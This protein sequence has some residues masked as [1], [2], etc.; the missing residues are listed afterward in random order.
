MRV[1]LVADVVGGVR[2]FALELAG[3]LARCGVG[4]DLALLG[5]SDRRLAESL[6]SIAP[7]SWQARD[8]R[9]EWMPEPW[10]DVRRASNWVAELVAERRPDVLHMNTFTPVDD[11]GIPVLLTVH[12]C[13]LTW[14]HSVHGRQP[15]PNW[16]GYRRLVSQALRRAELV[17]A[18]TAALLEQV[19]SVYGWRGP[20]R[21][22][23]NGRS[24]PVAGLRDEAARERLAVYV[25]RLWDEAKNAALVMA[26]SPDIG[27]RVLLIG[28]GGGEEPAAVGPL[29]EAEVLAWLR[30]ARVFVE[31]A[32]YEPFGL[33]ALEA[34]L[35][36]C[37]LVLGDIPSLR[38][39]WGPAAQYVDPADR[40]QLARE[41]NGLLQDDQRWLAAAQR[42]QAR[43]RRY[44]AS[45]M[46]D[47][48]LEAYSQLA[49]VPL[50]GAG[51]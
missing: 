1:L 3:R 8:L 11:A 48:Y 9:L 5:P 10:E 49:A 31:P 21:V 51:R 45:A 25:G 14:W 39:I 41:V 22:V 27:G 36:G 23:P 16:E 32:R 17:T 46:A 35:C 38:E 30:R 50:V 13:V 18:P 44:S 40:R 24:V 33:A 19:R 37:A 12:S 29:P 34:A 15:P 7:N 28:Q 4:L 26:A 6:D 47:A 2:T 43:A 42:A 20:G